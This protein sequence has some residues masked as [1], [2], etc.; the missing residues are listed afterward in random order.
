LNDLLLTF[1]ENIFLTPNHDL[2]SERDK[3]R[4]IMRSFTVKKEGTLENSSV[5]PHQPQ[6]FLVDEAFCDLF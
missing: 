2:V 6:K 4:K 3:E 1:E 5:V